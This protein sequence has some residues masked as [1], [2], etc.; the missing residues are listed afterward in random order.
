MVS[1]SLVRK[2]SEASVLIFIT[3]FGTGLIGPISLTKTI[4]FMIVLSK[5]TLHDGKQLM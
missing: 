4:F 3:E 5:N 1:Q 2:I